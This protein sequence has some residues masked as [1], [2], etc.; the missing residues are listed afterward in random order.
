MSAVE[1]AKADESHVLDL[2]HL[3]QAEHHSGRPSGE[4]TFHQWQQDRKLL[5]VTLGY[6]GGSF[7][8]LYHSHALKLTLR[9]PKGLGSGHG[10]ARWL[11]ETLTDCNFSDFDVEFVPRGQYVPPERVVVPLPR[12]WGRIVNA[13]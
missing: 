1:L 2:F 8:R 10:A 6:P 4:G 9:L 13:S 11:R 3:L 12:V 5:L 7:A